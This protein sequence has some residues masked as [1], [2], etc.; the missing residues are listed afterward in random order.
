MVSAELPDG[1]AREFNVT[2]WSREDLTELS[3]YLVF[4]RSAEEAGI[5]HAL[6]ESF[7]VD[8]D[9]I[10]HFEA[11]EARRSRQTIEV[12]LGFDKG[13]DGRI[14][15]ENNAHFLKWEFQSFSPKGDWAQG[16]YNIE[17]SNQWLQDLGI[18]DN[19]GNLNYEVLK[20]AGSFLRGIYGSG[21]PD[22]YSLQRH[23][24]ALYGDRVPLTGENAE[25]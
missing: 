2:G 25:N 15:S 12:L 14:M 9:L 24:H 20:G 4:W 17:A 18:K 5:S 10:D 8:M 1:R 6:G 22:Y 7:N 21:A 16:D 13:Y 19:A 23:L 11:E 3:E